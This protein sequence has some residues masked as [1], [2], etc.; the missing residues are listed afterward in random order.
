[1]HLYSSG[2]YPSDMGNI[3]LTPLLGLTDKEAHGLLSRRLPQPFVENSTST[4][5]L[6]FWDREE[7]PT[8]QAPPI[9]LPNLALEWFMSRLK[10]WTWTQSTIKFSQLEHYSHWWPERHLSYKDFWDLHKEGM[11][12]IY[13]SF[14]I[15]KNYFKKGRYNISTKDQLYWKLVHDWFK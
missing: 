15:H 8:L 13:D 14:L 6:P 2:I 11:W 10:S 12:F 5:A 9:M 3:H 1:M 7:A 4:N